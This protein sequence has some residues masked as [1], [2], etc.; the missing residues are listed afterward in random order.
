MLAEAEL[1]IGVGFEPRQVPGTRVPAAILLQQPLDF[2]SKVRLF[3][4]TQQAGLFFLFILKLLAPLL[5]GGTRGR[6]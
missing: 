3:G 4:V 1:E 2:A 6:V 5:G